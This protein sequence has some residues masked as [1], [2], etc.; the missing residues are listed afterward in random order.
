MTNLHLDQKKDTETALGKDT[1]EV[2]STT[3][4]IENDKCETETNQEPSSHLLSSPKSRTENLTPE[5]VPTSEQIPLQVQPRLAIVQ[6]GGGVI[7]QQVHPSMGQLHNVVVSTTTGQAMLRAPGVQQIMIQQAQQALPTQVAINAQGQPIIAQTS[8]PPPGLIPHVQIVQQGPVPAQINVVST[9]PCSPQLV[10]LEQP[11]L[12]PPGTPPIPQTSQP[13]HIGLPPGHAAIPSIQQTIPLGTVPLPPGNPPLPPGFPNTR[14]GIP[15]GHLTGN[16]VIDQVPPN[17]RPHASQIQHIPPP[18]P[19]VRPQQLVRMPHSSLAANIINIPPSVDVPANMN[20][21]PPAINI[22]LPPPP[23]HVPLPPISNSSHIS[24]PPPPAEGPMTLNSHLHPK[25]D[26]SVS[27]RN[28]I[29]SRA[30]SVNTVSE[31]GTPV[32]STTSEISGSSD[33]R[34]SF[35]SVKRESHYTPFKH[36]DSEVSSSSDYGKSHGYNEYGSRQNLELEINSSSSSGIK[37]EIKEE[38]DSDAYDPCA[39]TNDTKSSGEFVLNVQN[40]I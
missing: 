4:K 13:V 37:Q 25:P 1:D 6:P 14:L 5:P 23:N 26:S 24:L 28:S 31:Y 21:P 39:P 16:Q 9:S 29:P 3:D 15:P 34:H 2:G 33:F 36:K 20:V 19:Q 12:L 11:A 8:V 35:E 22:P 32:Q 40:V 10:S 7:N 30:T 18:L 17:I 38:V 27:P